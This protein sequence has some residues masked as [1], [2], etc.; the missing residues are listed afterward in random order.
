[1]LR[2]EGPRRRAHWAIAAVLTC[3][4]TTSAW[5]QAPAPT[6]APQPAATVSHEPTV[7]ERL[8]ALEET[9]K[10]LIEQ[11]R[12]LSGQLGRMSE[13]YGKV[14]QQLQS[15]SRELDGSVVR[16]RQDPSVQP[17]RSDRSDE[18]G[19]GARD[20]PAEP[21]GGGGGPAQSLDV[22]GG[23]GTFQPPRSDRSDEGGA[24][25]R[26]NPAES[27]RTTPF[28]G[29]GK[30][31]LKVN[32]GPG[33]EFE[34]DNGEYQFQI[35]NQTQV[36]GRFYNQSAQS[37]GAGGFDVPRE[38]FIIAGRL[39][40]PIEYDASLE[41][42]YGT[43]NLLNA[44]VNWHYDDRLM[45]KFGRFKVPY[46]YEYYAISNT[47]LLQPERS[48][49][50]AN[51]GLNRGVGA[52]I[53]GQLFKKS[54]DYAVGIFDGPRN[55][56]LDFNAGKDV[57]AYFD[58]RPF[59]ENAALPALKYFNIG[60]SADFGSQNNA[61][62]PTALR[63]SVSGTNNPGAFS[64]APSFFQWNNN[65][66]ESGERAMWSLHTAYYYKQLS[67]IGEWQGAFADYALTNVVGAKNVRVPLN[68]F[69]VAAGY[70][71]TG[72]TVNRRSQVRPNK[73]FDL[74]K[75]SFGLGAWELQGR[76]SL[77]TMGDEV[78]TGG[79]ADPN[80]WTNRV[81]SFDLG[82]NWYMNE[83]LKI[84]LDWQHSEFGAPVLYAPGKLQSS[85]DLFWVR[86][87]IYF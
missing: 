54:V 76:Y 51:F 68:G 29:P 84:Y 45:V 9:N 34:T 71:L 83:Y 65:V 4:A 17:P 44:F 47:D 39:S 23:D 70:F 25:A 30:I 7:E 50:G 49:F 1:M 59:Q 12:Q 8:R 2:D 46:L 55:Q 43:V 69:Y 6:P 57:I 82:L 81:Q 74:R 75:K 24:G 21:S 40:K 64:A 32:F 26:D 11:N 41:S 79:L 62:Y 66:I 31:P 61:V 20:N 37:P 58:A 80:I 10:A 67:V 33:I 42:A 72:E 53:W 63:T 28:K 87:Q 14:N 73:P 16:A 3:C 18:G 19:A 85:S 86:G 22:R 78:F 48:L 15:L 13:Q 52:Q 38:R 27:S 77:L 35:H 36:E 56:Q 5:G 60:G